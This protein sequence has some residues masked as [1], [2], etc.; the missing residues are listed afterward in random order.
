MQKKFAAVVFDLDGTLSDS[1]PCILHCSRLVH[2]AMGLPWDEEEQRSYI[3]LP[4]KDTAAL[5]CGEDRVEEYLSRFKEQN[6]IWLPKLLKAFD[7]IPE[8]LK[9]LQAAG[10][11]LAV[12]TSRQYYGTEISL[13]SI[14][15]WQYMQAIVAADQV[16]E[17]KPAPEPAQKALAAL[18]IEPQQ[19][20]FVGDSPVDVGCG[21]SAGMTTIA[22]SW[23][24][25][26]KAKLEAAQPDYICDTVA[27]LKALLLPD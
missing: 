15:I 26:P 6:T 1:V 11:A 2:E 24:I 9:D 5:F 14:G 17:H 4:L 23:G 10:V 13:K 20:V 22:V 7:G 3:S 19:A 25:S 18:G 12:A 16:K 27:E 21:K 8:L